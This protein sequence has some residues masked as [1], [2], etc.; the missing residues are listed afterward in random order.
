MSETVLQAETGRRAGSSDARR[1]RADGKI[2]AEPDTPIPDPLIW[3]AFVTLLFLAGGLDQGSVADAV[4]TVR[5]RGRF[6]QQA[7]PVGEGAMAAILGL[8]ADE[9][10][11]I[12]ADAARGEVVTPA[13]FNAPGQ[14]VVSGAAAA[15]KRAVELASA[16]G[17]RRALTVPGPRRRSATRPPPGPRFQT[18]VDAEILF[19]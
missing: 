19:G 16:I 1:L 18:R 13:N 14:T 11:K 7:V 10:V 4:R 17:A 9:L 12:C 5:L 2:P 6:M 3:L 8:D 15:V